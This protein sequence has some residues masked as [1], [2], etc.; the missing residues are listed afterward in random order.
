MFRCQRVV[1]LLCRCGALC[2]RVDEF[3]CV[4]W[5]FGEVLAVLTHE[6]VKLLSGVLAT[7]VGV[8]K[9]IEVCEHLGDGLTVLVGGTLERFLH[10][11]ETLVEQFPAQQILDLLEVLARLR[12]PPVVL[13]QFLDGLSSRGRQTPDLHLGET[14][15]VVE[16]A[17]ELFALLEYRAVEKFSDLVERS[18]EVSLLQQLLPPTIDL[19]AQLVQAAHVRR[20]A[21]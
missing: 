3:F 13:R 11:R 17:C 7:I 18:V 10:P 8:E 20:S 9:F 4:A 12:V 19:F 2:E 1:E 14:R 15:V 6:V 16:I 5:V 21:A